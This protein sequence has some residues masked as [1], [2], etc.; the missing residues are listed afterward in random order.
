MG[1]EDVAQSSGFAQEGEGVG[2]S[3]G[4]VFDACRCEMSHQLVGGRDDDVVHS[5]HLQVDG[6]IRCHLAD[7]S[8][9]E[10]GGEMDDVHGV[11]QRVRYRRRCE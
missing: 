9:V 7:S 1:A 10:V 2:A 3:P 5:A 4:E 11:W 6:Q 8:G